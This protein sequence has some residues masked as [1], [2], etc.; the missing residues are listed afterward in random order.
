ML[1]PLAEVQKKQK[2]FF[3]HTSGGLGASVQGGIGHMAHEIA[4]FSCCCSPLPDPPPTHPS[5]FL[6]F[7]SCELVFSISCLFWR[8][9]SVPSFELLQFSNYFSGLVFLPVMNVPFQICS[10]IDE[11]CD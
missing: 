4:H 7:F 10:F 1:F 9:L 11:V 8:D 3:S 2:T 6:E 5:S